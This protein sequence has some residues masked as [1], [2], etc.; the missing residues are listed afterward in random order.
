MIV[1]LTTLVMPHHTQSVPAVESF[2]NSLASTGVVSSGGGNCLEKIVKHI[3][4]TRGLT[5]MVDDEDYESLRRH[6]WSASA[7][8]NKIY[9]KRM[10][11]VRT[12][13][14]RAIQRGITMHRQILQAL[15]GSEVDHKNGD[16]LDNRKENLRLCNRTMNNGNRIKQST[17][18][19]AA[20]SS[21]YK[22][23]TRRGNRW[24]AQL[25]FESRHYYL[26]IHNT[27]ELAADAYNRKAK[28]LFGEYAKTNNLNP[29][30]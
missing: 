29:K 8:A 11:Y 28:Q 5:A 27:E 13:R 10:V 7:R 14:G 19:G 21:R 25:Q 30:P 1:S 6:S 24:I 12:E 4:L 22:G 9:A 18:N 20:L 17:K 2:R 3:P 15:S 23:V 16:T 26:G